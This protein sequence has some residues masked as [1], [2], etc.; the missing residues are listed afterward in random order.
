MPKIGLSADDFRA[1]ALGLPGATEGVHQ[2]HPDFRLRGKVFAT[3]G[4]PDDSFGMVKLARE[5]QARRV[6]QLPGIFSPAKGQW[7]LQGSTLVRLEAVSAAQATLALQSAWSE[8]ARAESEAES[9]AKAP[10]GKRR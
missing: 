6:R 5:E 2:G 7:G 4:Y 1:L 10:K 9:R 8:L 3:L